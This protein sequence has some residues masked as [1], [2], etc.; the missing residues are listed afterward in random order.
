[1]EVV[2][3]ADGM[4]VIWYLLSVNF[5]NTTDLSFRFLLAKLYLDHLFSKKTPGDFEDALKDPPCQIS[6]LDK[7]YDQAMDRI[8]GQNRGP[9]G[10]ANKV[11][12]WIIHAKR[13]LRTAELQHAIAVRSQAV[14]LMPKYLPEVED[15]I[16]SVMTTARPPRTKPIKS[17]DVK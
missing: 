17:R 5:L 15:L 9:R 8:N 6:G 11:I 10:N 1:M 14:E 13:P 7:L 16:S 3:A 2:K 4:Y 12:C